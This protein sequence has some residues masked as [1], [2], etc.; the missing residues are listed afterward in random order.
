MQGPLADWRVSSGSSLE[1]WVAWLGIPDTVDSLRC[2]AGPGT[3]RHTLSVLES[4]R[5]PQQSDGT[6]TVA[7]GETDTEI[8]AQLSPVLYK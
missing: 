6:G 1:T 7:I 4:T 3:C 5:R 8:R 2:P